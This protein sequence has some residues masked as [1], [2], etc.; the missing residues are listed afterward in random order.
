MNTFHKSAYKS[1]AFICMALALSGCSSEGTNDNDGSEA[2]IESNSFSYEVGYELGIS[3]SIGQMIFY[4]Q[5]DNP[6]DA[7]RFVIQ[8]SREGTTNDGIDWVSLN[9][10]DFLKGCLA[11][12]DEAHPEA[13]WNE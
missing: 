1:L 3:G 10:E 8:M 12:T 13:V 4:G 6:N 11:G 7:C 5:S 9:E 2:I